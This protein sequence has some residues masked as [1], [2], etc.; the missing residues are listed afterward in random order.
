MR[1][2]PEIIRKTYQN[3]FSRR[4][5]SRQRQRV[6]G[7]TGREMTPLICNN[8]CRLTHIPAKLWRRKRPCVCAGCNLYATVQI[9]AKAIER[10]VHKRVRE[11]LNAHARKPGAAHKRQRV[12][13]GAVARRDNLNEIIMTR[14]RAGGRVP[15]HPNDAIF[16]IQRKAVK[17]AILQ[18]QPKYRYRI[19]HE[20]HVLNPVL[21]EDIP[22]IMQNIQVL[23]GRRTRHVELTALH[24]LKVVPVI[25][26]HRQRGAYDNRG[27]TVRTAYPRQLVE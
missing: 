17:V 24:Q 9:P 8:M 5:C 27:H 25:R 7:N 2:Q 20:G 26:H 22:D 12:K 23:H 14:G 11:P 16:R 21:R 4:C 10:R 19:R 1:P 15:G 18:H 13:A 3:L 6:T